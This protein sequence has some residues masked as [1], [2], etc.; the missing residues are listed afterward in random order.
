MSKKYLEQRIARLYEQ[1]DDLE[2]LAF[3]YK[4]SEEEDKALFLLAQSKMR[5]IRELKQELI[6]LSRG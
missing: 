5:E 1:I 2:T 3:T 6:K 4:L